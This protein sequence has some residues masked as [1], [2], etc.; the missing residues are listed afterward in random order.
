[1]KKSLILCL[2]LLIM[3]PIFANTVKEN[4]YSEELNTETVNDFVNKTIIK[5]TTVTDQATG[6]VTKTVEKINNTVKT[7]KLSYA[8][9]YIDAKEKSIAALK[10]RQDNISAY[11]DAKISEVKAKSD[12][13]KSSA[14]GKSQEQINTMV[15]IYDDQIAEL[16]N[17]KNRSL[18]KIQADIDI[19]Q[20]EIDSIKS[21]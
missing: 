10:E 15:A 13:I 12:V 11:Y 4:N 14:A 21:H 16:T 20:A 1:M 19:L 8:Q 3:A 18:D 7:G 5:T 6:E 2:A 17:F 9:A